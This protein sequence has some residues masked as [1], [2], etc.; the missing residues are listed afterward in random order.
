M[1]PTTCTLA[2][3]VR[4]FVA[5]G[6]CHTH[7]MAAR[8]GQI[9]WPAWTR[10]QLTLSERFMSKVSIDPTASDCWKWMGAKDQAG[11]GRFN[12]EGQ[13]RLA[14]R[15]AYELHVG[16]IPDGLTIDH[17][18]MVVTCVNPAHLEPVTAQENVARGY[19]HVVAGHNM[20]SRTHCPQGHPYDEVNTAHRPRSDGSGKTY[21]VCRSCERRR[22]READ[23][24]KRLAAKSVEGTA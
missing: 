8:R 15:V 16:P 24:A 2:G 4:R 23:R 12:L 3:C 14:H 20:R 6:L 10:P 9:E 11:Y 21:R 22:A 18:C 5:K 19:A 7:Y 17:L 1:T 13:S